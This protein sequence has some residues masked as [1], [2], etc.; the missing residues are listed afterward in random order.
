MEKLK[1]LIEIELEIRKKIKAAQLKGYTVKPNGWIN[2]EERT[3]GLMFALQDIDPPELM[4]SYNQKYYRCY[5]AWMEDWIAGCIES[6]FNNGH[7]L[8]YLCNS[9]ERKF[10]NLEASQLGL[11]LARELRNNTRE[12]VMEACRK[13]NQVHIG[14]KIYPLPSGSSL[15][16]LN[17]KV[18]IDGEEVGTSENKKEGLWKKFLRLV[19]LDK[20]LS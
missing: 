6:A 19:K 20:L 18:F 4:G 7:C 13:M 14:Q 5:P 15:M 9:G 1:D 3:C 16:V 2:H 17:E 10:H 8:S 12:V 11:K